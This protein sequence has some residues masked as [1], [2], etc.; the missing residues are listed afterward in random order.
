[1]FCLSR[2]IH[3]DNIKIGQRVGIECASGIAIGLV[4]GIGDLLII[5]PELKCASWYGQHN[6][7]LSASQCRIWNVCPRH[8]GKHYGGSN[9]K[10]HKFFLL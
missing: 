6:P 7:P 10:Q 3:P 9:K 1:M 8:I 4:V 5:L 2:E